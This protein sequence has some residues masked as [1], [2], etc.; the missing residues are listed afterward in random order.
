MTRKRTSGECKRWECH[1]EEQTSSHLHVAAPS[2]TA[3]GWVHVN[4]AVRVEGRLSERLPH[5][6]VGELS[7][8]L[9]LGF[10]FELGFELS[11][12][13]AKRFSLR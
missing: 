1:A 8:E 12:Q 10:L 4:L 13:G 6:G 11:L 5:L 7:A 3:K 9:E 2:D